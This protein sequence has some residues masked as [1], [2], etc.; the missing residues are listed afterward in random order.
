MTNATLKINTTSSPV[1]ADVK[2]FAIHK[3][4]YQLRYTTVIKH[5]ACLARKNFSTYK[6]LIISKQKVSTLTLIFFS[7]HDVFRKHHDNAR[8]QN[9]I[10]SIFNLIQ[11]MVNIAK[12]LISI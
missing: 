5:T 10:I 11:L 12:Y 3:I 1:I 7:K 9:I 4:P 2:Y 6:G 8:S